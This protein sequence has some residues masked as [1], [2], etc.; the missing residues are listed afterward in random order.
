MERLIRI[1]RRL[2]DTVINSN[3][4][5]EIIEV[6]GRMG[7]SLAENFNKRFLFGVRLIF[8]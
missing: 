6:V 4:E 3:V 2:S 8:L 5:S 7:E 1:N